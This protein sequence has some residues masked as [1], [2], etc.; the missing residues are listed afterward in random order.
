M[1]AEPAGQ[2]PVSAPRVQ[3][4]GEHGPLTFML[5]QGQETRARLVSIENTPAI[6][7]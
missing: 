7:S 5:A 6:T 1:G 3:V 4:R 2:W